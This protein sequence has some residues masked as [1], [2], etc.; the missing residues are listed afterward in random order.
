MS[1]SLSINDRCV[2]CMACVRVCPVEAI[3]VRGSD[4]EIVDSTC[5]ECGFCVPACPHDA[6]DV[7][8]D[9]GSVEEAIEGGVAVLILPSEAVVGFYPATPEQLV[10]A[11][12]AAGFHSVFFDNLGDELVA[13]EYLRLWKE[14][15]RARTWIRSTSPIVVDYVRAKY[16]EL[17][18]Y[19]VPIVT[20]TIALARFLRHAFRDSPIIYA[21]VHSAGPE[22][23]DEVD[24]SLS[25][26]ELGHVLAER[27]TSP[28]DQPHTL[29]VVPPESRRYLSTA[30]GLPRAMLDEQRLS[31]RG[32]MK[33][34][35]LDS[36]EAVGWAIREGK[37]LGFID[38]LPFEG[39]LDHPAL[40]PH[41]QL[42][43]RRGIVELTERNRALAPV[44]ERPAD[45]DL[46]ASYE[47]RAPL[48]ALREA[49]IQSV[50][51]EIGTAPGGEPWDCGAC[52]H[53][54]C[55]AFAEAVV[56]ER[57]T[58]TICP[59]FMIRRYEGM[60]RDAA[61]DALTDLYS[62]RALQDRLGEEVAR[63]NRTG[64]TLAMLFLD[65]DGFK[66]A[67]DRYG[68]QAG[69]EVLRC[70]ADAI[71]ESIRSTD[72]AARFGGDEFVVLLVNSELEGVERVADE[73]RDRISKIAVPVSNGEV[74]VT[75]S[76]GI[77]YHVGARDTVLA[78]DDLLAEADAA[79][80]IAKAQGGNR[81]HP[82]RRGEHARDA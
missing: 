35:G 64:S 26:A 66:E 42:F 45:V 33:L 19:L 62:F 16:P 36:L 72:V 49:D 46:S 79:V 81:I 43:W 77:A 4:L 37:T 55:T 61:H 10:N 73:I 34:R 69:N 23:T 56:R 52:G 25:L 44:I 67:N 47:P 22:G 11:C 82:I 74:G 78:A 8:G 80:Y 76:V 40:G 32:L 39:A 50:L 18:P 65:L 48:P 54:T 27:G 1:L 30:G 29:S 24:A 2:A 57:A 58:L 5:T 51:D 15:D 12:L 60:A 28:T 71:R 53:M 17:V 13:A 59:Y 14:K 3:S 38:I 63:A 68:H 21:G 20:P 41:D 6:I 75:V 70:V 9:T 7:V 31:S